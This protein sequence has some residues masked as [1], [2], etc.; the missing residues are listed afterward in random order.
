[1]HRDIDTYIDTYIHTYI[2][3]QIH[4]GCMWCPTIHI[5][6]WQR[7]HCSSLR[8]SRSFSRR[9]SLYLWQFGCDLMVFRVMLLR[10]CLCIRHDSFSHDVMSHVCCVYFLISCFFLCYVSS[11]STWSSCCLLYFPMYKRVSGCVCRSRS[12]EYHGRTRSRRYR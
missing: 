8:W 3:T 10:M 4:T 11:F 9:R 1:M 6:C 12:L 7:N 2:H 5:P